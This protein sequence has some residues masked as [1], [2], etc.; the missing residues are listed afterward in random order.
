MEAGGEEEGATLKGVGKL[1]AVQM[2][3]CYVMSMSRTNAIRSQ[4]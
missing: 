4:L 2:A 3:P 1:V